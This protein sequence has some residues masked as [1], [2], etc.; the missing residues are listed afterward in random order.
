MEVSANENLLLLRGAS[1][2]QWTERG[3]NEA[4]DTGSNPVRGTS[5]IRLHSSDE[6]SLTWLKRGTFNTRINSVANCQ[7]KVLAFHLS[8]KGCDANCPGDRNI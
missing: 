8:H 7:S 4:G 5:P 2:A 6:W 1:V 3:L